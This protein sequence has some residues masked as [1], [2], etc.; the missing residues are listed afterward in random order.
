MSTTT[1]NS[2]RRH[3]LLQ[4]ALK[5]KPADASIRTD[6]ATPT[7]TPASRHGNSEFNRALGDGT[8]Q[9][10]CPVQPGRRPMQGKMDIS[11]ALSTWQR[12]W[13]ESEYEGKSKVS[14]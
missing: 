13:I 8:E 14:N 11:G 9:A 6:M 5:A 2:T 10:E 3:R 1:R 7:G 4:R 12:R